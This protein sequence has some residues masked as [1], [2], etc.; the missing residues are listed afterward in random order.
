MVDH[1]LEESEMSDTLI[2]M[3]TNITYDAT[4]ITSA[5]FHFYPPVT[6]ES[7]ETMTQHILDRFETGNVDVKVLVDGPEGYIELTVK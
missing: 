2:A 6:G 4:G 7:N 5:T 3:I 1:L